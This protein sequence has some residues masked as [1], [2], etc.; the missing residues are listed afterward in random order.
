MRVYGIDFTSTPSP[1][2]PITCAVCTFS[3]HRL[4]LERLDTLEGLDA[5]AQFLLTPGRW[6]AGLDFPFSQ[7]KTFL[8][9]IGWPSTHI[10]ENFV[11]HVGTLPRDAFRSTLTAYRTPRRTGDKHHKREVDTRCRSQSPQ[12]IDYTPVGLMFL[13]GAPRLLAADVHIPGLR[14]GDEARTCVEAY[15]GILVET[16]TGKKGYKNDNPKKQT[17]AQIDARSHVLALLCGSACRAR[18]DLEVSVSGM[19]LITDGTGDRL[20]AL[21]CA[22]QAAWAYRSGYTD[23]G[24]PWADPLEGWIADPAACPQD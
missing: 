16:L 10:W 24:P 2:K 11:T 5:F 4:T 13:E 1:A 19:D 8:N 9:N 6:V 7:S 15:P 23:T 17:V 21:L 3:D 20:D 22:V 12:T 18:Y 14:Q